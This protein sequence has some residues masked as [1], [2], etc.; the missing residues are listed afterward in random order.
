[1]EVYLNGVARPDEEKSTGHYSTS[2]GY[3]GDLVIGNSFVANTYHPGNMKM[4]EILIWEERLSASD[5]MTLS[6]AYLS[7]TA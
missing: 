5:I 4:D 3:H 1:M 7:L 6:N 2:G